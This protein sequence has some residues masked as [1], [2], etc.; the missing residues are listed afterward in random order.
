MEKAAAGP[1]RRALPGAGDSRPRHG[2]VGA[3]GSAGGF[4][5]RG[6][7]PPDAGLGVAGPGGLDPY[8]LT[9]THAAPAD[10]RHVSG[11]EA[12]AFK[13][14]LHGRLAQRERTALSAL[15]E[16]PPADNKVMRR[17][18]VSDRGPP[19]AR[20]PR[21]AVARG[22]A[23]R[24]AGWRTALLESEARQAGH[25]RPSILYKADPRLPGSDGEFRA[26]FPETARRDGGRV[27]IPYADPRRRIHIVT[28]SL[29]G[30]AAKVAR[31]ADGTVFVAEDKAYRKGAG[32]G[33]HGKGSGDWRDGATPLSRR[34]LID[35]FGPVEVQRLDRR[36][37]LYWN[38]QERALRARIAARGA[39]RGPPAAN[40]PFDRTLDRFAP[41][42]LDDLAARAAELRVMTPA[43]RQARERRRNGRERWL[44]EAEAAEADTRAVVARKWAEN[45]PD[46][47]K[48]WLGGL[49][50]WGIESQRR[51]PLRNFSDGIG[52]LVWDGSALRDAA[53]K[54]QLAGARRLRREGVGAIE[55]NTPKFGSEIDRYAYEIGNGL[56]D[57]GAALG[58]TA[59]TRSPA[60][61][62]ALVAAQVW[63]DRY[64]R[65]REAGRSHEQA[66]MDAAVHSVAEFIPERLAIGKILKPGGSFAGRVVK[67]G[68]AE[69]IQGMVTEAIQAGYDARI[70]KEDMS[71][72][73]AL[74]RLEDAA[75]IGG[76]TGGSASAAFAPFRRERS[77]RPG[78]GDRIDGGTSVARAEDGIAP[79]SNANTPPAVT[80]E[81]GRTASGVPAVAAGDVAGQPAPRVLIERGQAVIRGTDPA[82]IDRIEA[83]LPKGTRALRRSDGAFVLPK[84]HAAD[85]R[86]AIRMIQELRAG[87]P[88]SA[89]S[90]FESAPVLSTN[91]FEIPKSQNPGARNIRG[92]GDGEDN[93]R[94]SA[95]F[96]DGWIEGDAPGAG[97]ARSHSGWIESDKQRS[98]LSSNLAERQEEGAEGLIFR[99]QL[100]DRLNDEIAIAEAMDV[101]PLSPFDSGFDDIISKGRLKYAIDQDGDLR[102]VPYFAD[103]LEISHAILHKGVPVRSAG[104]VEIAGDAHSGYFGIYIDARSGHYMFGASEHQSEMAD[105]VARDAFSR[106]GIIF[107]K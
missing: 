94:K 66:T 19:P 24:D 17:P 8:G 104:I 11:A 105:K 42:P 101:K 32:E 14:K 52:D 38:Q 12:A 6:S 92:E 41:N 53:Y 34:D 3:G 40:P 57:L 62:S 65:S 47:A 4:A 2:E 83:N 81:H 13:R 26:V 56:V 99:N 18:A 27:R 15:L 82:M 36:L 70:L 25:D 77:R 78:A 37:E 85:A 60:A 10:P 50:E 54:E 87:L 31:L 71:W 30:V 29:E 48:I 45:L 1:R 21:A 28:E 90:A 61:G 51:D 96:D 76:A 63:G 106:F 67:G 84:R 58:V 73:D 100:P 69:A 46:R 49:G 9:D 97:R 7:D 103:G 39:D 22:D 55:A 33:N 102:V 95:S 64:G 44:R 80:V 35:L 79:S 74:R 23:G 88:S 89:S 68:A 75:I 72:G 5:L 91:S 43:E 86:T 20:E 98:G 59:L 93:R 16:A 107:P